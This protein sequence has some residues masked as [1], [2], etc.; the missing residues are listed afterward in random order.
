M[1]KD[2]FKYNHV[3]RYGK[4]DVDGY[5]NGTV[6]V[7]PK[8]DGTSSAI[9]W[10]GQDF[11]VQSRNRIIT[12][13]KDN[14]GFCDYILNITDGVADVIRDFCKAHPN[15]VVYGEWI[16]GCFGR[17]FIG[18]IKYY[19]RGGFY[20]FDIRDANVERS[21][22]E[23]FTVDHKGFYTP[24]DDIFVELRNLI[25][26]NVVPVIAKLEN[27]T[28]DE[29]LQIVEDCHY[30]V[31]EDEHVEGVVLKNY[32]YRDK[33]GH[34]QIAKIVRKEYVESKGQKHHVVVEPGAD[35]KAIIADCMLNAKLEKTKTKVL[36]ALGEDEWKNEGK[37]IGFFLNL[38]W[39]DFI[40]EDFDNQL[41]K[42]YNYP[43][44][45]FAQ[46]KKL[47]FIRGREFLGL[48]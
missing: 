33:Y 17:K 35:E 36:I 43:T 23:A 1:T 45:N 2:F 22:I 18:T 40:N 46:L 14:A 24:D 29:L 44:L 15:I 47:A 42:R 27:P 8:I 48:C 32:A 31:P 34:F 5:L 41:L 19:L 16:G 28:F 4:Q 21:D 13:E 39:D 12:L 30:I 11:V 26:D 37:F 9:Y 7:E 38:I 10:D 25:P 3:I 6:Y 20:V